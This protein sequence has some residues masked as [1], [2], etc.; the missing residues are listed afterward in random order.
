VRAALLDYNITR[1]NVDLADKEFHV[2]YYLL[3]YGI[4]LQGVSWLKFYIVH[5][6]PLLMTDTGLDAKCFYLKTR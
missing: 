5:H 1:V 4:I 2:E 6:V 3:G